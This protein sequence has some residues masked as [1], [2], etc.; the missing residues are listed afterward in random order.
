MH[1]AVTLRLAYTPP[2]DWRAMIDFLAARAIPGVETV[3]ADRYCRSVALDGVAGMVEVAAAKDEPALVARLCA[4][5]A[6]AQAAIAARLRRLFDLDADSTAIDAHLAAD[7]RLR[8]RVRARPGLR[9]PGA[10]DGFELAV[11]A[12]LGQQISVA[13]A[14]TF[15]GRLVAAHGRKLGG[16]A[17]G[18]PSFL[19]PAPEAVATAALTAIGLTRAR[20]ATL[21]AL[22]AAT[23]S[24]PLLL[25]PRTTLDETVARL[26]ALP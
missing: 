6:P 8:A 7:R 24:D 13:A 10:W 16:D 20:A 1:D 4:G 22:A 21:N 26:T 11:R 19:F 3:A 17:A 25:R 9:V 23:A 14:T 5:A 18:G 15:A 12:V 2:Y